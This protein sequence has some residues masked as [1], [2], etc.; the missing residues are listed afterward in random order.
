ML[1]TIKNHLL[2]SIQTVVSQKNRFVYQPEK[3]FTRDRVLSMETVIRTILGM[4]GKSL[5]KELLDS[6]LSVSHSAFVQKRYAIKPKAFYE[7]FRNFTDKIPQ[8][9]ELPILAVDGSDV[10][11]PRNK[12]DLPTLI[13]THKEGKSYN[14]I[15]LNALFDL[16]REIYLDVCVQDKR[17]ANEQAGLIQ[18]MEEFPF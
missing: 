9:D 3:Q 2:E 7:L 17:Q 11:I 14:V 1:Q 16:K 12:K 5:S 13:K 8:S 10:C 6:N 18:M 4:G 15:H